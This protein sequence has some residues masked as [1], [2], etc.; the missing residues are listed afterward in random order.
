[1]SENTNIDS[2][3]ATITNTTGVTNKK[4]NENENTELKQLSY[5]EVIECIQ[6]NKEVPNLINVPDIV[7][8]SDMISK[9]SLPVRHKPWEIKKNKLTIT[10]GADIN[11]DTYSDNSNTTATKLTD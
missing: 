2:P 7:L 4:K 5:E 10:T 9:S 1:M 3:T 8:S 11:T 6:Q